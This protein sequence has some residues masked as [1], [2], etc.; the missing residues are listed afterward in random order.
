MSV[1]PYEIQ[2]L[3]H[4][5]NAP[6]EHIQQVQG[7]NRMKI[8]KYRINPDHTE[9]AGAH[10]DNEH[11][12]NTFAQGSGCRNGTVHK[13]RDAIGEAHNRQ[14]IHSGIHNCRISGKQKQKRSSKNYQGHSQEQ[15]DA[16][17]I[18]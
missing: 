8:R 16:E 3:R 5:S 10:D 9:Y 1:Y 6:G 11:R 13:C 2:D 17:G 7:R 14:T 15:T 18:H 4:C 12:Y